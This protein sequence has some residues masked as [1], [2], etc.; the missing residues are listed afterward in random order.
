MKRGCRTISN[1]GR[2]RCKFDGTG[3]GAST[4]ARTAI[5]TSATA[6]CTMKLNANR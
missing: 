1:N 3:F 5:A 4:P 2:P 6:A